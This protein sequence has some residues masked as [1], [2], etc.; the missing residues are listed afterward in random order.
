MIKKLKLYY[1]KNKYII[2]NFK[3][4]MY[5]LIIYGK[6]IVILVCFELCSNF[7]GNILLV[8]ILYIKINSLVLNTV[9]LK[10]SRA[11]F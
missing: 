2:K 1:F 4:C 5:I 8:F 10:T 11:I 6:K 3:S 9:L 7:V